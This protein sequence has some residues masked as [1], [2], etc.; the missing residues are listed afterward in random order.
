MP[1]ST[2]AR[3][4]SPK[5]MRRKDDMKT[6]PPEVVA[7]QRIRA[8]EN[9]DTVLEDY[10]WKRKASE[11]EE[12]LMKNGRYSEA[13]MPTRTESLVT[14]PVLITRIA[15]PESNAT[16]DS[17][18]ATEAGT[19]HPT[20]EDTCVTE[21]ATTESSVPDKPG[22]WW[23]KCPTSEIWNTHTVKASQ[24]GLIW[25]GQYNRNVLVRDDGLWGGQCNPPTEVKK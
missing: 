24:E 7:I 18:S 22:K 12:R 25:V 4:A 17:A 11:T 23:R 8:G 6:E 3:Y 16:P 2:T 5:Q 19:M 20:F 1:C 10:G 21:P 9:V 15:Y 13:E 14:E